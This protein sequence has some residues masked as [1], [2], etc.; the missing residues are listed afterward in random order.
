MNFQADDQNS[1]VWNADYA[2]MYAFNMLSGK[3]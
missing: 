1:A 3:Q 2:Q